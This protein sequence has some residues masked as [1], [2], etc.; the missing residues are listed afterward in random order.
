MDVRIFALTN[1]R[2]GSKIGEGIAWEAV[3]GLA[4]R[5]RSWLIQVTF[6]LHLAWLFL[7]V[8]HQKLQ[9]NNKKDSYA[10]DCH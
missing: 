5:P 3:I 10:S 7:C 6:V 1:F 9:L 4:T 2:T 8:N